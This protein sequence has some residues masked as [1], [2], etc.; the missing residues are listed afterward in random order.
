MIRRLPE[1]PPSIVPFD[2][3]TIKNRKPPAAF[4]VTFVAGD[5]SNNKLAL[6]GV[7]ERLF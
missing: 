7:L 1:S 4:L 6:N 2:Y 3:E 5:K